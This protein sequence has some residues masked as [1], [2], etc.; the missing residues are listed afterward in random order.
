M[1][2]SPAHRFGQIIGEVLEAAIEPLLAE[3]AQKHSLYL[4]KKGER[5]CRPGKKCSWLD[6]N[7]NKHDLDYVLERGGTRTKLGIPAAFIETAWR[8]YTKH[9]RNKAQEIQGAIG[10][11][12]ETYK[13]AGPFTGVILAGVFT[14]G[15]LTQ[16]ESLGFTVLY[17]PYE[18]VVAVF[19]EFGIDAAFNE[20]TPDADFQEK[21]DAYEAMPAY[22]RSALARGLL[23]AHQDGVTRFMASLEKV[24]LRQIERIIVLPLHGT[25]AELTT[26]DDAIK[27]INDYNDKTGNAPLERYE[28]QVRYNNGN[29]IEG[30]FKDK[31]SAVEF[32]RAYQPLPPAKLK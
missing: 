7:G 10:P 14:K 21:V 24:V 4:D 13:S 22:Q 17:F 5:P 15:A 30:K 19:G 1:A 28:I 26:V 27:F 23:E 31:A 9:S 16:L 12:V 29:V 11:L 3:F 6:R 20:K 25:S 8:R 2:E 18:T 32:L